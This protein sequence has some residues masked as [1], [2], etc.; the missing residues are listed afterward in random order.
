[1]TALNACWCTGKGLFVVTEHL[2]HLILKSG[3]ALPR[4]I[5]L[6]QSKSSQLLFVVNLDMYVMMTQLKGPERRNWSRVLASTMDT[7]LTQMNPTH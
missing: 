6:S 3:M 4:T 5:L 7:M 1:M 2:S